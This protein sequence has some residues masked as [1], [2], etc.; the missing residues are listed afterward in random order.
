MKTNNFLIKFW[1][2]NGRK[3][4][5]PIGTMVRIIDRRDGELLMEAEV[6]VHYKDTFSRKEGRKQAIKKALSH[7]NLTKEEK[8]EIW[9]AIL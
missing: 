7:L 9:E 8:R 2:N 5:K 3:K 1:H 6:H 4:D